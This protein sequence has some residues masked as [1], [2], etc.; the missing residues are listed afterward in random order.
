[1]KNK[2]VIIPFVAVVVLILVSSVVY[3]TLNRGT[4][5]SEKEGA[6]IVQ[7][8]ILLMSKTGRM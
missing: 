5:K 1:M 4:T 2:K 3:A 7:K 6:T 8:S